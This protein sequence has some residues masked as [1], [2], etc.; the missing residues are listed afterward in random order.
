MSVRAV[1]AVDLI[2]EEQPP[3]DDRAGGRLARAVVT[4]EFQGDL[5]A[6]SVGHLLTA[7][8]TRPGSGGYVGFE[9]VVGTLHG[10]LG[11]FVLQHCGVMDRGSGALTIRVVPDTGTGDLTGLTG[12]MEIRLV[13][14]EHGFTF[15]YTVGR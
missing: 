15:D 3:Y 13:D 4:K 1:G 11:S 8:A 12:V 9:R 5:Q 2:W 6:S 14:G 7:E 10:R